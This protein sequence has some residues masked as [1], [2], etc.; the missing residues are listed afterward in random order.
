MKYKKKRKKSRASPYTRRDGKKQQ[1]LRGRLLQAV[2]QV[3]SVVLVD[4]RTHIGFLILFIF[5]QDILVLQAYTKHTVL[6][7][8]YNS[9]EYDL[10][11]SLAFSSLL[12]L[13]IDGKYYKRYVPYRT[14]P[15]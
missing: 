12:F 8:T 6:V 15:R 4:E 14:V 9:V 13:L 5:I 1:A 11:K 10:W 3:V 7:G 2:S